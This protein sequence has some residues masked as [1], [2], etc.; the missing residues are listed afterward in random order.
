MLFPPQFGALWLFINH[1]CICLQIIFLFLGSEIKSSKLDENNFYKYQVVEL[2]CLKPLISQNLWEFSSKAKTI[3]KILK[4]R[5]WYLSEVMSFKVK[6]KHDYPEGS[7]RRAIN[8]RDCFVPPKTLIKKNINHGMS[9]WVIK[10]FLLSLMIF[11]L[12]AM[13]DLPS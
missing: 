2:L 6:L 13:Y 3:F 7:L 10:S 12:V 8:Y 9:E 5:I 4:Q 11:A 1:N